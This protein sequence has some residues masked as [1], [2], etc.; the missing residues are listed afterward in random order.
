MTSYMQHEDTGTVHSVDDARLVEA[1]AVPGW[2][3]IDEA[4]AKVAAP[5]L[6]G[7]AN[8]LDVPLHDGD[9]NPVDVADYRPFPMPQDA[10]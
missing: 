9:G 7:A 8:P 6:F 10:A 1:A 5:E 4:A 3:E 2:A